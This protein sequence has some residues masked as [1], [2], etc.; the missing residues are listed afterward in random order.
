MGNSRPSRMGPNEID[1]KTIPRTF[2]INPRGG[3]KTRKSKKIKIV[4]IEAAAKDII[5]K[6][7]NPKAIFTINITKSKTIT[8]LLSISWK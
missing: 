7:K 2:V 8:E 3:S 6:S 1:E 5:S 4:S